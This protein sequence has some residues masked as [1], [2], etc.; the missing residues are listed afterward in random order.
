[1][2]ADDFHASQLV[3][4][5]MD[6]QQFIFNLG[7][8][9]DLLQDSDL[10]VNASKSVVLLRLTGSASAAAF[11]QHTKMHTGRRHLLIPRHDGAV[12]LLPIHDQTCYLGMVISY[13]HMSQLSVTHRL[14]QA[15]CAFGRLKRWLKP[16][17]S[18]SL[19]SRYQ[20]WRRC[21][22]PVLTYGLG[23]TGYTTKGIYKIQIMITNQLR[24][25]A[26]DLAF[27]THNTNEHFFTTLRWPIP[28]ELMQTSVTSQKAS[29]EKRQSL[30]PAHDIVLQQTWE[31]LFDASALVHQA[32]M[33]NSHVAVM[34]SDNVKVH[35]TLC[36]KWFLTTVA[37][38]QHMLKIHHIRSQ[39]FA[40]VDYT[41]DAVGDIPQCRH[42]GV[43]LG[44]WKQFRYHVSRHH[45]KLAEAAASTAMTDEQKLTRWAATEQG[46]R[47]LPIIQAGNLPELA[48]LPED[49]TWL[50]CHCILCGIF[51]DGLGGMTHHLKQV[52]GDLAPQIFQISASLWRD[53]T[54]GSPC[55][56]CKRSYWSTHYCP[57][58]YQVAICHILDPQLAALQLDVSQ[59]IFFVQARDSLAG[60]PIC[61]HCNIEVASMPRLRD[62]IL[63]KKCVSFDPLRT[64]TPASI[65]MVILRRMYTGTGLEVFQDR[66]VRTRLTLRCQQCDANFTGPPQLLY[67]LQSC[68]G[69]LWALATDWCSFL[70]AVVQS[71]MLKCVCNPGPARVLVTRQCA[72]LRQLAMMHMRHLRDT[73]DPPFSEVMLLPFSLT[74]EQITEALPATLPAEVLTQICSSL[75]QRNFATLWNGPLAEFAKQH[76]LLCHEAMAAP[77]L[78][79]HL[80]EAHSLVHHGAAPLIHAM[81]TAIL[82]SL[83]DA[84]LARVLPTL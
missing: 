81:H 30:L 45:T 39:P 10:L 6:L 76:C 12:T 73:I 63:K 49:C 16:S 18:F 52:H 70:C 51:L 84:A 21:I 34:P 4:S 56:M 33:S 24:F 37:L 60:K 55:L 25:I 83:N 9:L 23:A 38:S 74:Q 43:I 82:D 13:K 79:L 41:I 36:D 78:L 15:Q 26:G 29:L 53:L 44:S 50:S 20:L 3:H 58:M 47:I 80:Q 64:D 65:D 46:R 54:I 17:D 32:Q 22:I 5:E 8:L 75:Q 48:T 11:N 61:A 42:C 14:R 71:K 72:P 2:Y 1:M 35:C 40:V 28:L 31:S 66:D 69:A 68:H 62:H 59:E 77:D 67:H 57:V 19:Q 7:I 27:L